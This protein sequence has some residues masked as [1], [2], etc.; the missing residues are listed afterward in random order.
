M[1]KKNLKIFSYGRFLLENKNATKKMRQSAIYKFLT[2]FD[3]LL[4]KKNVKNNN[5]ND[6]N[7]NK[8]SKNEK[9]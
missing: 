7:V 9:N 5:C 1:I 8:N 4:D 6:K 2:Q 3:D